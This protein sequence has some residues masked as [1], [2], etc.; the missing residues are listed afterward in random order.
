LAYLVS[1]TLIKMI[2]QSLGPQEENASL[3]AE[4][5]RT[6]METINK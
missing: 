6:E 3:S 1:I 5:E 2:D 4:N